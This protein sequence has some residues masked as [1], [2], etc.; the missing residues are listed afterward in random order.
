MTRP[1][2]TVLTGGGS[3]PMVPEPEAVLGRAMGMSPKE[4]V[5]VLLTEQDELYVLSGYADFKED[6][7]LLEQ[8]K[9]LVVEYMRGSDD[10]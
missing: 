3:P 5:V 6:I 9:S 10:D 4:V 8:G 2:L 1:R 7:G